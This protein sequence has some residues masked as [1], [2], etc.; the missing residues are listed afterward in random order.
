MADVAW[1]GGAAVAHECKCVAWAGMDCVPVVWRCLEEVAV[2]SCPCKTLSSDWLTTTLDTEWCN[3]IGQYIPTKHMFYFSNT[4][5][6]IYILTPDTNCG[7]K[8]ARYHEL[9]PIV[10]HN[11]EVPNSPSVSL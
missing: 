10:G 11:L 7:I 9:S 1:L 2:S 3:L 4:T 6:Y 8:R 5:E